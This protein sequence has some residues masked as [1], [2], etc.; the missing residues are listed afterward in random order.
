MKRE[1]IAILLLTSSLSLFGGALDVVSEESLLDFGTRGWGL[2]PVSN[3]VVC[4]TVEAKACFD[5][6][7]SKTDH[8]ASPRKREVVRR[9]L[10]A[11]DARLVQFDRVVKCGDESSGGKET[12]LATWTL[13]RNVLK[14]ELPMKGYDE[15][16]GIPFRTRRS[17]T[18][19]FST[20][21]DGEVRGYEE[22]IDADSFAAIFGATKL[23]EQ[24]NGAPTNTEEAVVVADVEDVRLSAIQIWG[25]AAGRIRP[26]VET[27]DPESE[28]RPRAVYRVDMHVRAVRSGKFSF[29]RFAFPVAFDD[30]RVSATGD[31]LFFR[32]M[33][34]E[35]G[36][37][38]DGGVLK[39]NRVEPVFPYPPYG[40]DGI[41]IY[42]GGDVPDDSPFCGLFDF[43][44]E[45]RK[46]AAGRDYLSK[47]Y[48][49][50]QY[51]N[52]ELATFASS[53]NLV[54]GF[55]G[56]YPDF[57]PSV[58][59]TVYGDSESNLDYWRT[60]WFSEPREVDR[61][62]ADMD[63]ES[64]GEDDESDV[65]GEGERAGDDGCGTDEEE[66]TEV[67]CVT[68]KDIGRA[69]GLRPGDVCVID[70]SL[71]RFK[72]RN[73]KLPS[74]SFRPP[75]TIADVAAFF[76][77]FACPLCKAEKGEIRYA[78]SA[79]TSAA[80]RV[81][82]PFAATNV[83]AVSVLERVCAAN[84]CTF[85]VEGTNV[86]IS[87]EVGEDMLRCP[88]LD[89]LTRELEAFGVADVSGAVYADVDAW[90]ESVDRWSTQSEA[91]SGVRA[92]GVKRSGN[93]WVVPPKTGSDAAKFLAYG[94]VWYDARL[95]KQ[96]GAESDGGKT[97][98]RD[99]GVVAY[100]KARLARDVVFV[101]AYAEE[102]AEFEAVPSEDEL[103]DLLCFALHARQAG[104]A[105]E[106]ERI[107]S[108]LFALP[109]NGATAV[110]GLKN[111]LE[112]ISREYPDF[113]SWGRKM[114][115]R[116]SEK[117]QEERERSEGESKAK[118]GG[119]CEED[120]LF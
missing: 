4:S 15:Q 19:S 94:C 105:A 83:C 47:S 77:V 75:A 119:K 68:V 55:C 101:R 23:L 58:V 110:K 52:S 99:G 25:D 54:A 115:E 37:A 111:R 109:K 100:S 2:N 59:I 30:P 74:V 69:K 116:E 33:T 79:D 21:A 51:G 71:F 18:D 41:C 113:E 73:V 5:G 78:V 40:K 11:G 61:D 12:T 88:D 43:P 93:G 48:A 42:R 70:T 84:G 117:E 66:E 1:H 9:M 106:A 65:G 14:S 3:A 20:M 67:S 24:A 34:L 76:N 7:L 22:N 86:V 112:K 64:D 87:A 102:I 13:V 27:D 26:F 81:V 62:W 16:F 82:R 90:T 95:A 72:W 56:T 97:E 60:A 49:V 46:G 32:G 39:V 103:V 44:D 53:T 57:G 91:M 114:S 118:G 98:K 89:K 50:V 80:S 107:A 28:L 10:N 17:I 96:A 92:I 85:G 6:I 63:D 45:M 29:G 8:Y 120:E 35:V 31:W 38:D 104:F 36:F 108:A